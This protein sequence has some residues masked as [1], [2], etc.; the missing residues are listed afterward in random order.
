MIG[1]PKI[2]RDHFKTR[3]HLENQ[4]VEMQKK[5]DAKLNDMNTV[6]VLVV[7]G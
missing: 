5:M 1:N 7:S 2:M 3:V 4:D 6:D